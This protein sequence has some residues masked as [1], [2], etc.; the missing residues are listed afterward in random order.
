[1]A[2]NKSIPVLDRIALEEKFGKYRPAGMPDVPLGIPFK[3]IGVQSDVPDLSSLEKLQLIAQSGRPFDG[4]LTGGGIPRTAA[5]SYSERY[6]NFMPGG[7]NNEDAYGQ[8]QSW[9]SKMVDGV[10]KGL[11]LTGTTFLQTTAGSINGLAQWAQTGNFTSFYN[12]DFNTFISR[13]ILQ[14]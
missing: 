6:P 2:D 7:Y 5:E 12:N 3:G 10:G 13:E 4:R 8:G 11:V 14:Y 1:M 9:A